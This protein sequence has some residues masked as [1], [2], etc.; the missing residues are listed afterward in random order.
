[1]PNAPLAAIFPFGT[2]ALGCHRQ[3]C[4]RPG[5]YRPDGSRL[6]R[7]S[8]ICRLTMAPLRAALNCCLECSLVP[9]FAE[10][11]A[12]KTNAPACRT[13]HAR[14]AR[15][16]TSCIPSNAGRAHARI[17][18]ASGSD[19]A[20]REARGWCTLAYAVCIWVCHS[21]VCPQTLEHPYLMNPLATPAAMR[22][23]P[24][25]FLL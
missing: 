6:A 20:R 22:M 15:I 1:M 19:G 25:E 18:A 7:T 14:C 23:R 9:P 17:S 11:A 10:A 12:D 3:S 16:F 21:H 8:V 24:Q 2:Q 13:I 4:M 5:P